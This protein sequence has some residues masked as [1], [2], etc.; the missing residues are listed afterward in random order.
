MNKTLSSKILKILAVAAVCIFLVPWFYTVYFNIIPF[1][2]LIFAL[3]VPLI[4]IPLGYGIQHLFGRIMR[5]QRPFDKLI[6]DDSDIK[7]EPSAAW[8][9][10]ILS[11]VTGFVS[12]TVFSD[13]LAAYAEKIG[14]P[15]YD[16]ASLI[17]LI[18]G[19]TAA[20]AVFVGILLWFFPFY[21]IVSGGTVIAMGLAMFADILINLLF[22]GVPS[23]LL[24]VCLILWLLIC[25][26]VLNQ[27]H[28]TEVAF[29]T[30]SG[31]TDKGVRIFNL[32][33]ISS[34]SVLFAAAL[35][36]SFVVVSGITTLIRIGL[37]VIVQ[38][39][40][41][42]GNQYDEF[43]SASDIASDF[44][45]DVFGENEF[46][47]I[48][49]GASTAVF[50][51]FIL[52]IVAVAGFMIVARFKGGSR[53]GV[54][55]FFRTIW[56]N[57]LDFI[58]NAIYF[59][60]HALIDEKPV[61]FMDYV[62]TTVKM[63]ETSVHEGSSLFRKSWR[64]E[65]SACTGLKDRIFCVYRTTLKMWKSHGI[66]ILVSDTPNEIR[67]KVKGG[68]D[69]LTSD[70]TDFFILCRYAEKLPDDPQTEGKLEKAAEALDRWEHIG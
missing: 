39:F 13:R 53:T 66:R 21:R 48:S 29:P 64:N 36:L 51:I 6:T 20:F 37:Y 28:L 31:K 11:L 27:G 9:P 43:T 57:I 65:Y 41:D 49:G 24:T 60:N 4:G 16:K 58:K 61:F 17:P 62:D 52:L 50:V 33:L 1:F 7:F 18:F 34:L 26:A 67:T 2:P 55:D 5:Y 54:I 25:L 3:A 45:R 32:G 10:I 46:T 35:A 47:M 8:L 40:T 14:D 70:L 56:Q 22:G 12:G 44:R 68:D 38:S 63:D 30:S 59:W 69:E 19:V 42:A 15:G 23:V